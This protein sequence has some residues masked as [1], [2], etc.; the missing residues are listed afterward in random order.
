MTVT[1]GM[2]KVVPLAFDEAVERTRAA[3]QHEG[4]GVLCDIDVAAT[5]KAKLGIERDAYVILGA[6]NPPLAHKALEA[7]QELGLLLPCNVIVYA[8]ADGTR[9][10]A[11]DPDVMLGMIDNPAL[12]EV[13][14]EVRARLERVMDRL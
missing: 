11:I 2:G 14:R 8:T 1:Y 5:L 13:A 9:V 6:C 12:A 3:L 10:S 4:F 7:E